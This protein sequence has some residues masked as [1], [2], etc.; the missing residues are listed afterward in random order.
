MIYVLGAL[1][2][3]LVFDSVRMRA[4]IGKLA[5]LTPSDEPASPDYEI[6]TAPGVTLDEATRRAATNY[7][8]A[9]ELAVLDLIPGDLPAIPAMSLAQLVD[10]VSYRT[11]RVGPGRTAGHALVITKDV[12]TRARVTPPTDEVELVQL[13]TRL[14]HYG[15]AD[16][17]IAP[18]ERARPIDL[19][20]R[21]DVLRV[22]L[23]PSVPMALAV[24]PI[25]WTIIGLGIWLAPIPGLVTLG[26][27]QLQPLVALVGT[28]L[29]SRDVLVVT[30]L[31]PLVEMWIL[32]RTFA[33]RT[34]IQDPAALRRPEYEQLIASGTARFFEPR[35]ETCPVCDSRDLVVHLRNTDLLQH[36]PG[37]F[38]LERCRTCKHVFQNPGLSPAGLDYYYK[39]FYDGLGEAGMDLIFGFGSGSY[40]ARAQMVRAVAPPARWLDVGAGH[41]HFCAAA[42]DDLPDT[43]FDGLDFG[44][45][46]DEAQRRGWIDTAYRGLFPDLAPQIAG[47][48]NAISMSHYLEHT[49]DPR[50][51]LAAAHTALAPDGC[52]LIEV[53]DPEFVLGRVLRNYWLPWFQPQHQHLLSVKNLERL[54]VE[55]NFTPI[56]WHRGKAHQEVDFFFATWL[57]LGRIAPPPRLPWRWRGAIAGAWRAAVWTIG[58]PLLIAAV[59]TDHLAAPIFRRGRV[60]NTYRVVAR[61]KE[62]S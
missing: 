2:L 34:A 60:S 19:G 14:K 41:G 1:V 26:I 13:A 57:A 6:I 47:K 62:A 51:E 31:R 52:L 38:T 40:H 15:K 27:W 58:A 25:F 49:L 5:V 45:S 59:I 24:L 20:R 17:A 22:Y 29:H 4:R 12:V 23:G 32:A 42:R 21:F 18:K 10:P 37:K 53:P 54:L 46:I 33:G 56:E 39:D 55:H 48:Y 30:L 8:R 11:D 44:E 43:K 3:L 61:R 50:R 9:H 36:K 35:R 16:L 7:A 28:R